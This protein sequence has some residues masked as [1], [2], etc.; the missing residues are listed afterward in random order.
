[1]KQQYETLIVEQE[2]HLR[3]VTLTP[4]VSLRHS[5]G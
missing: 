2:G 1:M 3:W 5:T 4:G